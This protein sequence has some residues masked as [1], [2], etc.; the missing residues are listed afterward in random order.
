[1]K[2]G[3]V[4]NEHREVVA[5]VDHLEAELLAVV[6]DGREHVANRERRM[7]LPRPA[8]PLRA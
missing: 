6:P 4:P 8:T 2:L 7:V 5:L 1:M 3:V